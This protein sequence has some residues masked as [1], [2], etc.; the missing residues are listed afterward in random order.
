MRA[1][2]A[3]ASVIAP[4]A[5]TSVAL[6]NGAG[7]GNAYINAANQS[8]L[9]F[10]VILPATSLSTDTVTLTLGSGSGMVSANA[11]GIDGGGTLAFGGVDA[12]SLADGPI[13]IS[14]SSASSYGDVSPTTSITRTKDTAAPSLVSLSMRDNNTNGKVDRVARHLLGDARGVQRRDCSL[15]AL[16]RTL[17]RHPLLGLGRRGR[18]PR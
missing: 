17:G 12:S 15:D 8:S 14:A 3:P 6:T 2:R 1:P 10:D 4:D 9:S 5:P 16:G 11:P 18:P 13:T 7:A